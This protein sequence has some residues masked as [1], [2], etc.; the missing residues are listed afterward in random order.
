LRSAPWVHGLEAKYGNQG[1]T[2]IGVHAPEYEFEKSRDRVMKY[3]ERFGMHHPHFLDNELAYFSALGTVRRPEFLLVDRQ[4]LLRAKVNG[5]MNDQN[6]D[7][8]AFEAMVKELLAEE[9]R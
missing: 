5:E 9:P 8:R 4:G 7:S 2:V 1:L 6:P 3:A